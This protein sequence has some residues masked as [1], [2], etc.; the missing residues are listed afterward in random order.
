M[1]AG[2]CTVLLPTFTPPDL[3]QVL[4]AESVTVVFAAPAY[5]AACLSAGLPSAEEVASFRL[6]VMAGS[7]VLPA[8]V[9]GLK[10]RLGTGYVAQ[11]WGMTKLQA[12]LYTRPG[13][14]IETVAASAGRPSPSTEVRMVGADGTGLPAGEE[15]EL[16]VRS[17]LLFAGYFNPPEANRDAFVAEG[18]FRTGDFAAIGA[19]GNVSIQRARPRRHD[20]LP[21]ACDH[22]ASPFT[23]SRA[24]RRAHRY[25]G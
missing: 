1:A 18:W 13:D 22:V 3:A 15:G 24:R 23:G 12:G 20:A 21:P 2:A 14:P 19:D 5:V 6:A 8:V 17:L 11:L 25:V 7:A 4:G 9:N 16:Q 10:E